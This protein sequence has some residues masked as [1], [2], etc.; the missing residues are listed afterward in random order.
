M[1]DINRIEPMLQSIKELWLK[2]PDLRLCQLLNWIAWEIGWKQDDLFY[3]EDDQLFE[4]IKEE[5]SKYEE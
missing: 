4:Q 3:L 1:R 2:N 5:L